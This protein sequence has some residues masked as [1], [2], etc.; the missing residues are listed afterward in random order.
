M[1]FLPECRTAARSESFKETKSLL[2]NTGFV[3]LQLMNTLWCCQSFRKTIFKQMYI[4]WFTQA[5]KTCAGAPDLPGPSKS[6]RESTSYVFPSKMKWKWHF[7][8]TG[9]KEKKETVKNNTVECRVLLMFCSSPSLKALTV[10][11]RR[12]GD[13]RKFVFTAL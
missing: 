3:L 2:K 7:A 12:D 6:D 9:L 13:A 5:N 11:F 4:Q 10:R 8:E 1:A